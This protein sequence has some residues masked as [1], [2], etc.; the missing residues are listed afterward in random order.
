MKTTRRVVSRSCAPAIHTAAIRHPPRPQRPAATRPARP[1][2]DGAHR[3]WR[4]RP[5]APKAWCGIA[6]SVYSH[7]RPGLPGSLRTNNPM[8]EG[9]RRAGTG[10]SRSWSAMPDKPV[11]QPAGQHVL[12]RLEA[13]RDT[14]PGRIVGTLATPRG[15][16][17]GCA[18]TPDPEPVPGSRTGGVAC[19]FH[20]WVY[21]LDLRV[22]VTGMARCAGCPQRRA[23]R[24]GAGI[25]HRRWS[26][27][28]VA[29]RKGR[30][31][32]WSPPSFPRP[33]WIHEHRGSHDKHRRIGT[34]D[35]QAVAQ[36]HAV[37]RLAESAF[38]TARRHFPA[39]APRR[40]IHTSRLA[41]GSAERR[42]T[43]RGTKG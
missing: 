7:P 11:G 5:P 12:R 43:G 36:P 30:T 33:E 34:G 24:A 10:A 15:R 29:G 16:G 42:L 19:L 6:A 20:S 31:G 4:E 35:P 32:V 22:R 39:Q 23:E 38:R 2:P 17:W 14:P 37:Q 25:Q 21:P 28:R 13:A 3:P 1:L 9:E 27:R 26:G 41:T 8:R 18:S 40:R